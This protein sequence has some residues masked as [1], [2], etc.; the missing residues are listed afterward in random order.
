MLKHRAS[1]PIRKKDP[2]SARKPAPPSAA[3]LK[4][5]PLKK[6]GTR[7]PQAK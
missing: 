3:M 5:R 7:R 6:A 2:V 1:K 4:A